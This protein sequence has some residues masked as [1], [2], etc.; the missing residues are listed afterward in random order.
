MR[1]QLISLTITLK[2][3]SSITLYRRNNS[4][5]VYFGFQPCKFGSHCMTTSC[6]FSHPDFTTGAKLKW[7]APKISAG[8][9]A[10]TTTD[11]TNTNA[12]TSSNGTTDTA[13]GVNK[14][15]V[16]TPITAQ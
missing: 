16:V 8:L 10:N 7:V 1:V 5:M 11:T 13:N 9:P 6:Q 14:Q 15:K 4:S 3:L 2:K 12:K